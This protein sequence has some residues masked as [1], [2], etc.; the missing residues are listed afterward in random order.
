[1]AHSTNR[2]LFGTKFALAIITLTSYTLGGEQ[3][4]LAE[5]GLTGPLVNLFFVQTLGDGNPTQYLQYLGAGL[6]KLFSIATPDI[7]QPT[8]PVTFSFLAVVQGS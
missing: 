3:F 8:G 5:F 7:E 1:M 6:I 4:T 2:V